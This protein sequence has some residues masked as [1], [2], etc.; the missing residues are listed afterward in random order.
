MSPKKLATL[1]HV[2]LA[3]LFVLVC[4]YQVRAMLYYFPEMFHHQAVGWPFTP[5]YT[6]GE[7]HAT[8]V[9]PSG[10]DAGIKEGDILVAINGRPFTATAV[11][12]EAIAH[13]AAGDALQVTVRSP[14]E[15]AART[16]NVTLQPHKLFLSS[17]G[18]VM[19]VTLKIVLPIFC[20][21]LGFW[22][23]AVRPRDPSAWLLVP[24]LLFLSTYYNAGMESWGPAIRDLATIYRVVIDSAWPLFMFLFGLYFPERS[25]EREDPR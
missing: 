18:I 17:A 2:C 3:I 1:Q 14:G 23:A 4:A 11:Y 12:G 15:A 8:F 10:L 19:V 21:L 7:P 9:F 24:V 6:A 5:A 22:V 25:S 16:A 13:A 20:I